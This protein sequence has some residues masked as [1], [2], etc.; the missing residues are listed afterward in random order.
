MSAHF[1]LGFGPSWRGNQDGRNLRRD[2]RA[3]SDECWDAGMHAVLAFFL[4]ARPA[5]PA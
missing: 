5:Y 2:S 3:E 1:L 4:L